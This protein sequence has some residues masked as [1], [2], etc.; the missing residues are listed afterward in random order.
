MIDRLL[1]ESYWPGLMF[2]AGLGLILGAWAWQYRSKKLGII[3]LALIAIGACFIP[4]TAAVTTARE[5]LI[6]RTR[7]LVTCAV[8]PLNRDDLTAICDEQVKFFV[9]GASPPMLVGRDP[10]LALAERADAKYD[11]Q[12]WSIGRLEARKVN[13]R[14]GESFLRLRTSLTL[15]EGIGAGVTFG[16]PTEWLIRWEK[17]DDRA[18]WRVVSIDML[19]ISGRDASA[20]QLP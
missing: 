8:P 10:L 11:V 7:L 13:S 16:L 19:T 14:I 12:S 9:A 3:A 20:A 18:P 1:F 6:A 2:F 17:H 15:S 5:A 4:L